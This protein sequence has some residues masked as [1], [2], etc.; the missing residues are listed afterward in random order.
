MNRL[1]P[2]AHPIYAPRVVAIGGGHGLS[3]LLRGLKHYTHNLSAI[4]TVADDGGGSGMLRQELG[5]PAPGDIRN[6]MQALSNVEPLMSELLEYRF[7][8][9]SLSGQS[10]GNL[11]LAALNGISP[12]FDQAVIGM[13]QVLAI[14][15]QVLPVTAESVQL[16]ALLENGSRI[17]GESKICAMKKSE[18]CRIEA[19]SLIPED[20]CALP[21]AIEAIHNAELI[22]AG[23]G[24]LYTSLIPNLLVPGI[25]DALRASEAPRVY[26]ANLMTQDGETEHYT[27]GD[28]IA[29]LY[30]HG[31]EGL[32]TA[33]L[34]NTQPIPDELLLPAQAFDISPVEVD[35][36]RIEA[37]GL[38]LFEAA[39]VDE[40]AP[41][42]RHNADA[43]TNQIAHIYETCGSIKVY[44]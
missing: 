15:G 13:Q 9:G 39:L 11:L 41:H 25:A 38:E 27:V 10:F 8:D 3:N 40:T 30:K 4:V 35:R 26:I 28:H 31:G 2:S 12:S 43:L 18:N 29:A 34:V 33:C 5:M 1:K 14:T 21:S 6:C 22:V 16:A 19:V 37:F 24:S 32:F 23:P 17:V 7:T 42:I 20:P 36:D 44:G